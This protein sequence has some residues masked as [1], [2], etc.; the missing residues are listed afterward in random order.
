M[1]NP[2]QSQPDRAFWSRAVARPA[3]E[4]VDPVSA[5]GFRITPHDRVAT[6]G[7]CFAQHIS[8][9]IQARGFNY[10]V[11]EQGPEDRQYGVY[12][13]RFGNLYTARQF[14]QLFQ[15]AF[16]LYVPR[17][18][19][20]RRGEAFIDPFRPQIEADGFASLEALIAD[21][22]A[23]LAAVRRM[24]E[25]ADVLVF[26]LGLTEG[27]IAVADGATVPLAPGVAGE[28]PAA[29]LYRPHNFTVDEIV[30]DLTLLIRDARV[31]RPDLKV[32]LTVSP[33][34]LVATI[35]DRHVLTATSY[36]KAV[37]RVAAETVATSL[38][39]VDYFPSYEIVTGPHNGHRFLAEDLRS[40]RPEGV[41]QVMSIFARH[42]LSD[43]EAE[44]PAVR[45]APAPGRADRIADLDAI[46]GVICDE[47]AIDR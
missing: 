41:A 16:G 5:V 47:E 10:L 31:L 21:R 40:V 29:D 38:D 11:T 7:S 36:S 12:P 34:P 23:H 1:P 19:V 37:L 33:V 22:D 30:E 32:L 8:R 39:R 14:R 43:G 3:P 18:E 2:Y 42:Y 45:A 15:R 27:W 25:T 6:A 13:A 26:T 44:A 9:A 20:W 28:A 4:D 24:F 35:G 46:A 17:D